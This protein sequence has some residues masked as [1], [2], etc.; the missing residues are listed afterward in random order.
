MKN[1]FSKAIECGLLS[2]Q[3][4]EEVLF[5]VENDRPLS[6]VEDDVALPILIPNSM[7]FTT[8]EI[9]PGLQP[10]QIADVDLRRRANT[11]A[12]ATMQCEKMVK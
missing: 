3:E 7:M 9:L 6:Y 10:Q 5:D 1:A 8:T 2:W 11:F 12:S 4:L